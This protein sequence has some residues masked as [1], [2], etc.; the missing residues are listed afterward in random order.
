MKQS[1]II[2]SKNPHKQ[3]KL[4]AIVEKFYNPIIK[5]DLSEFEETGATFLEIA[6]NKALMLSKNYSEPVIATDG[7]AA[8]PALNDW[9]PLTTKRFHDGDDFSRIKKLLKMMKGKENRTVLWFEAL[10]V[11]RQGKLL[12][13]TQVQAM[14][15]V[16][17][18]KFN[19][20]N[21]KS[22]I[23]LCSI[24]SYPQFGG[25]NYF[26]LTKGEKLATE[27]NWSKLKAE[28][29]KQTESK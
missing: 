28:F 10:A 16:I 21:Y 20:K 27:D 4:S 19:P 3:Q 6:Q 5:E 18:E 24:T 26:D 12:F 1:I 29:S 25:R 17:D 7:G 23:W 15:G 22:G 11:A 8:I 14:D 9:N 2:G 13:S